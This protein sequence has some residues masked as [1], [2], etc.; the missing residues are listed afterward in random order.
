MKF[1]RLV[2]YDL[3][4]GIGQKKYFYAVTLVVGLIITFAFRFLSAEANPTIT[5]LLFYLF[6]GKETIEYDLNNA[7]IFPIVW[8]II[9]IFGAYVTLEYPFDNMAGHGLSVIV[10]VRNRSFWWLSKCIY[11]ICSTLLYFGMWYM[12]TVIVALISDVKLSYA[13]SAEVNADYISME[14]IR[15][16]SHTDVIMTTL[17]LP[18]L[19]GIAF[20][21]LMLC[22]ELFLDRLYCFWMIVFYIFAAT[23]F[24][25]PFLIGNFAMMKRSRFC[26]ENGYSLMLETVIESVVIFA[27]IVIGLIRMEKYDILNKEN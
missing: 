27:C 4:N 9:Y 18:I 10:R 24:K 1:Y 25:T 21:M 19:T 26:I 13:Y 6:D 23:Y 11:T 2:K 5:N 20:N 12:G 14:I 22:M 8:L 3:K 17:V 15:Q 16:L 7:F